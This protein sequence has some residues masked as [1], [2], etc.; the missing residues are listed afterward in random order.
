[1]GVTRC[2]RLE[3]ENAGGAPA[4]RRDCLSHGANSLPLRKFLDPLEPRIRWIDF[5]TLAASFRGTIG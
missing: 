4:L 5:E 3:R 1:M 2:R